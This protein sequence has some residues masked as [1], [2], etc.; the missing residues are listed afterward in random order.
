MNISLA[1]IIAVLKTF[2]E[3]PFGF[4]IHANDYKKVEYVILK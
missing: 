2:L 1:I 3:K 4:I